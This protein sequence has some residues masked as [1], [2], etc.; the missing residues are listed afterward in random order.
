M[1]DLDR[2]L[3]ALDRLDAVIGAADKDFWWSAADFAQAFEFSDDSPDMVHAA[4]WSPALAR[5]VVAGWRDIL[6]AYVDNPISIRENGWVF[7]SEGHGC[8]DVERVVLGLK[9]AGVWKE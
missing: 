6:A 7:D 4:I 2:A 1:T 8:P 9:A 3:A 5:V